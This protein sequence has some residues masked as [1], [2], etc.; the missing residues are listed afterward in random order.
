[1]R[2][3]N[4]Q[5]NN[6]P[7]QSERS[8]IAGL[9]TDRKLDKAARFTE[10]LVD[11][12][13]SQRALRFSLALI[14][15]VAG[16]HASALPLLTELD[17]QDPKN[18]QILK[19]LAVCHT[20]LE[21]H[22]SAVPCFLKWLEVEPDSVPALCGVG[23]AYNSIELYHKAT[24]YLE[25]AHR[26][27]PEDDDIAEVLANTYL[28]GRHYVSAERHYRQLL[29]D[30]RPDDGRMMLN[31]ADSLSH[32]D[33]NEE[34]L[35]SCDKVINQKAHKSSANIMKAGILSTLGDV[36]SARAH[37]RA[38]LK[39]TPDALP[40][41]VGLVQIDKMNARHQ[42]LIDKL[43]KQ[44]AKRS[45]S[46]TQRAVA[47]FALGKAA[48]DRGNAKDA[49]TYYKKSN[50]FYSRAVPYDEKLISQRFDTLKHIFGPVD[51]HNLDPNEAHV[52]T[53]PEDKKLIFI[54]GMPR[55]GTS[56]IEQILSSHSLVHGAGELNFMN[57]IT[58]ELMYYFTRQPDV[59][60]IDRAFG[61]I[62]RDYLDKINALNVDAP[63]IVDKLPH[64][65]LRLGFI[66][67]AFPDACIVHTNRD[68]MAVC[69][70]NYQRYFPAKGMNFGNDLETLGRYYKRY[71]D[72]M[73]FWRKK[74]GETIYELDY[75]RLTKN[76]E[77][78][79]RALLAFCGQEF[80]AQC[81]AFH[82]TECAV[83]TASQGQVRRK[84][85]TGSTQAW[86]A[87]EPYLKLLMDIL[88]VAPTQ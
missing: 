26:L 59:K 20:A 47:G 16:N 88:D 43:K 3:Q 19:Q 30:Q 52:K 35:E 2:E 64:N 51:F 12:Y 86:R 65:F 33:Y 69:W 49:F 1:M 41:L 48:H 81:L 21:D 61:S 56:L 39:V 22:R 60:L 13:P 46:F 62:G 50:A 66:R 79:T 4:P 32:L 18:P 54:V 28:E 10:Q 45:L 27:T 67:A 7:T 14:H 36:K 17:T 8:H 78:E 85:Y 38:A 84:M 55:S 29:T 6:G 87:Y 53:T 71:V 9:L 58:E 75:D 63:V 68:P 76:Q 44:F 23:S 80:E 24:E 31:L 5:P 73:G 40:A 11:K 72:L 25:K 42:P 37:Y 57:E 34:V 83:R 74:F 15:I 77:V 70:S 82:E